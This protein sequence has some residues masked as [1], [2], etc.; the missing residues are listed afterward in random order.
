MEGKV[1]D[2]KNLI[3]ISYNFHIHMRYEIYPN[4]QVFLIVKFVLYSHVI[5]RPVS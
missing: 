3:L 1:T 4:D 5:C 2:L